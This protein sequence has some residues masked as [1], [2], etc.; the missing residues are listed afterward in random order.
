MIL[1]FHPII[2]ADE[3]II[4]AGRLP[5]ETDLAA[6]RRAD[7]VILPQGCSQVL[8]RMARSHCAQVF[9]NMDVRFA[10]PGKCGQIRMF[11]E[12]KL[13][14]PPTELYQD[15][16]DFGRRPSAMP[17]PVVVKLDYGGQGDTVFK[18][19]TADELEQVLERVKACERTGQKGFLVQKYIPTRDRSLR[20]AVI[21]RQRIAYWRM[22]PGCF[23][24]SVVHGALIDHDADPHLQAAATAVVSD[25][26]RK[27][28]LGLAGFDFIFDA[29]DLDACRVEPLALE[30]NYFFGRTGLGGSQAYYR[31]L[32]Q[33][34]EKWLGELGLKK[35]GNN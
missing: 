28:H 16:D 22:A 10:Y 6:I 5:D 11:R 29:R 32:E 1:S 35:A 24:T 19:D 17:L 25:F 23:G 3:N 26:C 20:V 2:E 30:V 12:K 14:H 9:P 8:Y 27:T 31:I 34:I 4:C 13:A 21:G 18:A 15:L 33:E 7:A